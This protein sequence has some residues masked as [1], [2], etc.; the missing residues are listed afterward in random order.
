MISLL[1]S[2]F[3]KTTHNTIFWVCAFLTIGSVLFFSY[4]DSLRPEIAANGLSLIDYYSILFQNYSTGLP[5]LIFCVIYVSDDFTSGTVH[6]YLAKGISRQ[7]YYLSKLLSCAL[8]SAIYVMVAAV[9]GT[10]FSQFLYHNL[11]S[12][13]E[14]NMLQLASFFISQTL[15]HISY[16]AF[17]VFTC[18][19]FRNSATASVFNMFLLIFGFLILH[20]IEDKI[21]GTYVISMYWP[22]SMFQRVQVLTVA[23]WLPVVAV[24]LVI[25]GGLFTC[26]GLL[27]TQKRDIK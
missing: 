11:G 4:F 1:R 26:A 10:I 15:L 19:L 16:A 3:Y 24:I 20:K 14:V 6:Y 18:F 13:H 5:I 17:I 22:V 27:V 7:Q 12:F 9:S 21:W 2:Q 25:Y 8:V 23:E